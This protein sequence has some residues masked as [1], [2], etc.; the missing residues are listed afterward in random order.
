[1]DRNF[2]LKYGIVIF[3]DF[4]HLETFYITA[5]YDRNDHKHDITGVAKCNYVLYIDVYCIVST[6]SKD[7][8]NIQI[9]QSSKA[10]QPCSNHSHS[11]RWSFWSGLSWISHIRQIRKGDPG[12]PEL[13]AAGRSIP[14]IRIGSKVLIFPHSRNMSSQRI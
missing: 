5:A 3:D 12:I 14:N 2:R 6:Y 10:P 13:L 11:T 4:R 1:M 9:V 7:S 8:P